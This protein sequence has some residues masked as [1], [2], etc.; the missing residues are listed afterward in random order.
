MAI[1]FSFPEEVTHIVAKVRR[2]QVDVFVARQD[3]GDIEVAFQKSNRELLTFCDKLS[4]PPCQV[5]F[6]DVSVN[7]QSRIV[8]VGDFDQ[9]HECGPVG[10]S[11][12][13]ELAGFRDRF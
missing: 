9:W 10:S 6:F 8:E 4:R 2:Q 12:S 3:R 13:I 5:R 7:V 11:I 1:D